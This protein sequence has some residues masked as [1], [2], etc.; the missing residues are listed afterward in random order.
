MNSTSN[1]MWGEIE[2]F[3][4]KVEEDKQE[5]GEAKEYIEQIKSILLKH[6][7]QPVK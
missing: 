6:S 1:V 5:P 3:V 7:V 2:R 4:K